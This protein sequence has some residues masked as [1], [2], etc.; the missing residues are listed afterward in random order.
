[1]GWMCAGGRGARPVVYETADSGGRGVWR[2]WRGW[3]AVGL[4][5]SAVDV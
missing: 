3:L 1:M 2:L 5:A 4:L